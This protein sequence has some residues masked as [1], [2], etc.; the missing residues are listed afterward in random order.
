MQLENAKNI[1][2]IVENAK[3]QGRKMFVAEFGE[4]VAIASTE[5]PKVIADQIGETIAAAVGM[6]HLMSIE[7]GLNLSKEEVFE[8]VMYACF[9]RASSVLQLKKAKSA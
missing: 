3:Q 5:N 9:S 4:T 7:E 2:E 6:F 8:G 1:S